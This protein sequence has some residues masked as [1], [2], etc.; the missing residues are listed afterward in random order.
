MKAAMP[1]VLGWVLGGNR[2]ALAPE[3]RVTYCALADKPRGFNESQFPLFM[4]DDEALLVAANADWLLAP[5]DSSSTACATAVEDGITLGAGPH[6]DVVLQHPG[7]AETHARVEVEAG[8]YFVV[9]A[10]S[11]GGTWLNKR[12]IAGR[13]QLHP[14]DTLECGGVGTGVAFR[15][16]IMHGSQRE[17][18]LVTANADG[19]E[20]RLC[21]ST[22]AQRGARELQAR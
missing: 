10:G 17:A 1:F 3:D 6:S 7:C 20:R 13:T 18:G 22:K 16:K 14:G 5:L 12:R 8:R 4:R 15:V 19:T 9:D 11:Q 2:D 21:V